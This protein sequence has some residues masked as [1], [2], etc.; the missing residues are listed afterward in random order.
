MYNSLP[1][2]YTRLLPILIQNYGIFVIVAKPRRLPYLKGYNP[3]TKCEYHDGV[4]WHS[5][6]K[7]MVFKD[8]IQA[9]IDAN[10]AKFKKLVNGRNRFKGRLGAIFCFV[11]SFAFLSALVECELCLT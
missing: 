11:L 2:S 6:E 9:L 1:M 7:C 3:N 5:N 8:E 4:E 10:L